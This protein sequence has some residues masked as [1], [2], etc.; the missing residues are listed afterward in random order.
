MNPE[1][2]DQFVDDYVE[3]VLAC[4][5][6]LERGEPLDPAAT[7][8]QLLGRL[9]EGRNHPR[10]DENW[11]ASIYAI[12]AWTDELMLEMPWSGRTWWNNHVLEAGLFG[13]RVCSERFY[14]LAKSVSSD[15][16][17]GALRVFHDCVLLGFRG[18]Y[19]LPDFASDVAN[20]LGIPPQLEQWLHQTQERLAIDP[21]GADSAN[22]RRQ[23]TGAKP[24]SGR[25]KVVWWT[26]A[27]SFM[28]V[29]N[30]S[31]YSLTVRS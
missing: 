26:L 7:H 29:I 31:I 12:A 10:H 5:D 3:T 15:P 9:R 21:I 2:L 4:V 20:E 25:H 8:E 30:L 24:C 1:T 28:L 13:T 6:Q 16:S 23:L 22:Y 18:V 19:G 27:A 11:E 14:V 17:G